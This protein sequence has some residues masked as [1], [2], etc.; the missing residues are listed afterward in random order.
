MTKVK[1]TF[2]V[3]CPYCDSGVH[4]VAGRRLKFKTYYFSDPACIEDTVDRYPNVPT[5]KCPVC[6]N[7][8]AVDMSNNRAS[9]LETIP[10]KGWWDCVQIPREAAPVQFY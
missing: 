7:R 1:K 9:T 6:K 2:N 3:D 4:I 10:V 5:W 8:F